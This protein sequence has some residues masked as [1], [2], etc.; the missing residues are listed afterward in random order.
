VYP[1]DT[2]TLTGL[3][4]AVANS[5]FA[6][7]GKNPNAVSFDASGTFVFA[8][9]DGSAN[10]AEFSLNSATG[11]LTPVTGSPIPAGNNPD[12]IAVN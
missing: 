11:A 6:T 5:P 3:D 10:F 7:G 1:I 8:G 9:N 2:S 12:F 4:P